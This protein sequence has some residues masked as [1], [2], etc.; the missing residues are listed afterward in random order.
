MIVI[1]ILYETKSTFDESTGTELIKKGTYQYKCLWYS[2]KAGQFE[3]TW[4]SSRL[5][6]VI[7][8]QSGGLQ[9][10]NLK[11]G[12]NVTLKTID[13]ELGKKKIS[14]KTSDI[15][16]KNSNKTISGILPFTSPVMQIIGFSKSETK[17]PLLDI[18]TGE[19][20]RKISSQLVKCKF[21]NFPSDKF[22]DV[23]IPIEALQRNFEI[24][25]ATLRELN[26]AINNK[27][28]LKTISQSLLFKNTCIKPIQIVYKAGNYFLEAEDYLE[29]KII[30]FLIEGK[31]NQFEFIDT[32]FTELPS[33][34]L[35]KNKL[36][37][38]AISK[39][40]LIRFSKNNYWRI[41]YSDVNENLS[42][43][44]IFDISFF[45]NSK[46]ENGKKINI[47][48]VKAQCISSNCEE[49]FFRIDRIQ[50][51]KIIDIDA[52]KNKK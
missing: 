28:F 20:K 42:V 12:M 24:L 27:V 18:K 19:I 35:L 14:L 25:P 17:E 43:R 16:S 31:T 47:D 3:E 46:I 13:I 36:N 37:I 52:S 2:T 15:R 40:E 33:F 29:N 39:K 21:F 8:S 41:K 26:D 4:I 7:E 5:L 1:E 49:R 11:Y 34:K 38:T 6:K 10:D 48:Y 44:T 45:Q 51:I 23:L 50:K 30:D 22:S 32:K 9:I